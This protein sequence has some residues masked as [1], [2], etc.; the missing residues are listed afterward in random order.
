MIKQDHGV[1]AIRY[2]GHGEIRQV[3]QW[4]DMSKSTSLASWEKAMDRLAISSF[5]FVAADAAGNI[6]FFHNSQ[7]PIRKEFP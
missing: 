1:Y 7:S 6:G 5:N 4:F 3:E 2:A